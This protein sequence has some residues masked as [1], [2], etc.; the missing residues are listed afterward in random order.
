MSSITSDRL[1]SLDIT[2]PLWDRFFMVAPLVIVGTKEA[3]GNYDL[4]PKHMAMPFGWDNYFGFICTPSH[5]TYQNIVREKAFSVSFPQPNQILLTSLTATVRCENNQKP[6]LS[7]LSTLATTQIDSVY[8]EDSY[9][10]LECELD[11]IIDEFGDNS[12]IVGKIIAAQVKETALRRSDRDDQDILL[13]IPLLVYL[14]PGRYSIIDHSFSFP[15][16]AK[17]HR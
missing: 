3:D 13:D 7:I 2:Q 10:Y 14:P 12:L 6:L 4:A 17:F 9:L 8:L 15:F 11:R 16:H 1:I 5:G